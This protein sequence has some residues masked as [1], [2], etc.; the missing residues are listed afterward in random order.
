MK[1]KV[2]GVDFDDVIGDLVSEWLANYNRDNNDNLS[3]KDIKSWDIG[4]YTKIG[5]EMYDY[6]KH[7]SL[8]DNVKPVFNSLWGVHALR[9]MGY[10][11]VFITA[12]TTEQS[13]RKY[14]WLLEN[15]YIENKSDYY[16]AIDKSLIASDYLIDDN[17]ENV[18]NA[19][20][21]G[22]VYTREW[23]TSLIGYPRV[24]NW[25]EVIDFFAKIGV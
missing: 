19:Y 7:P 21:Q 10:R 9:N 5:K 11:V 15:G 8:Y 18:E 22:V 2:I 6:L 4:S 25:M 12:S 3:E 14:L 17:P 1:T 24:N 13:G 20:G 16:E 23:N